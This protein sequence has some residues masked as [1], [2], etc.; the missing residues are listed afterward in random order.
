MTGFDEGSRYSIFGSFRPQV[1]LGLPMDAAKSTAQILKGRGQN[2]TPRPWNLHRPEESLWWA[3]PS[4]EWPAYRYGKYVFWREGKTLCVGFHVEKAFSTKLGSVF[5]ALSGRSM[6]MDSSWVWHRFM[7]DLGDGR[8]DPIITELERRAGQ[9]VLIR[10][11]GSYGADSEGFD[12]MKPKPEQLVFVAGCQG[13]TPV[14]DEN[15]DLLRPLMPLR[16]ITE[17]PERIL[18]VGDALDWI[19]IDC[20]IYLEL[21]IVGLQPLERRVQLWSAEEMVSKIL[22]PWEPWFTVDE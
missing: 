19:W 4:T 9:S 7:N 3:I 10:F 14:K 15:V 1:R 5:P 13:I 18:T 20:M 21:E 12:P 17:I 2:V 11:A 22:D 16:K 8:M 6:V